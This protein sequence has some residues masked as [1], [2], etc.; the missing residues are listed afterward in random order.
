MADHQGGHGFHRLR[1]ARVVE[2][3]TEACSLVLDVPPALRER[4]E[5]AA[6]QFC[7]LRIPVDGVALHRC[8]S[9]ST[10]PAVDPEL[11]LTVKRVP[12]GSVSNWINDR[13]RAGDEVDVTAPAGTFRLTDGDGA[14]AAFAAGSGI[15][16]VISLI[17]EALATTRRRVHLFYA[18][19][20]AGSTIFRDELASLAD[21]HGD[22][23]VVE[24]HLDVERG[25]ADVE[26]LGGVVRRATP[27][28]DAYVCGPEPF[29]DVVESALA[30]AVAS[31]PDLRV[32]IE[33]F[34]PADAPPEADAG[35]SDGAN[36]AEGDDAAAPVL[37]ITVE[38]RTEVTQHHPG[39]TVLQ[40]ARQAGLAPPSS[41]EAGSCAT[42]MAR[43]HEGA[44]TMQV[45]DALTDEEVAEGW[46]LTCQS[47][48]TT[49]TLRVVF[50]Y[51]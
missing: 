32:H 21:G 11:A 24:H 3:T 27:F 33:R 4:F 39:T 23:L 7:T 20:D 50:G 22:R 5:Y 15:T 16:P 43:V 48:P 49:P 37:T 35:P 19:R 18:N 40:A 47:I 13:I 26:E 1:I 14:I 2:E 10:A 46:I 12:G 8:Y 9:M 42:C 29:M 25:F 44:V 38:D 34:T 51:D 31:D 36:S 30:P 41:C 6:G 17:K 28:T 45:N